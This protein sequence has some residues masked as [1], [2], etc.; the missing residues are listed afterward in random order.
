MAESLHIHGATAPQ[1]PLRDQRQLLKAVGLTL[2]ERSIS[3][4][5]PRGGG[6]TPAN[7]PPADLMII[8]AFERWC[9][10][11]LA[12]DPDSEEATRVDEAIWAAQEKL[13]EEIMSIEAEGLHGLAFKTWLMMRHRWGGR[14][15]NNFAI[16]LPPL[17]AHDAA[18]SLHAV[19]DECLRL[20]PYLAAALDEAA[21]LAGMATLAA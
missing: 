15:D 5:D 6:G 7:I 14:K 20:S 2:H 3:I 9:S 18:G 8:R 13:I 4:A 1:T 10:L 12:E 21:G 11:V 16:D 19:A 17:D